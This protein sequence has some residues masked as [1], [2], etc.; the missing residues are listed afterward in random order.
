MK[1]YITLILCITIVLGDESH[2]P[3]QNCM[4][5][6]Y[7]AGPANEHVFS[8]AGTVYTDQEG[9]NILPGAN[10]IIE[11]AEDNVFLLNSSSTFGNFW[12][13]IDEYE[14]E[15][16]DIS[17]N[18]CIII[19]GCVWDGDDQECEDNSN[20]SINTP[21]SPFFISIEYDGHS[22]MMP[23]LASN[24]SCNSCHVDGM[25]I[26]VPNTQDPECEDGETNND[27]PCN[28]WECYDGQWAEIIIDCPV[29]EGFPC[30]GGVY[31]PPEEGECCSE[32]ILS[33]DVNFD[34]EI[35]VLDVVLMV[36]FILGEPTDPYVHSA[37]DIN[38]DGILNIL[39]VVAL[40]SIILGN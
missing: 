19:D 32:C 27:N 21:V 9:S 39:D 26:Y 40:I 2:N 20:S 8:I 34:D 30:E 37:G 18:L 36:S 5:C 17:M 38:Q 31:I 16:D 12:F 24:G 10:I 1:I 13:D 28:P 23:T 35:N 29:H 7:N 11:D 25:R 22:E 4:D 33:G 6:H 15:C 14:V 3:G